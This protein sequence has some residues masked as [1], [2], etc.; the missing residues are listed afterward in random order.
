MAGWFDPFRKLWGW[1]YR[2]DAAPVATTTITWKGRSHHDYTWVPFGQD[3][4]YGRYAPHGRDTAYWKGR[5]VNLIEWHVRP[6]R[7]DYELPQRGPNDMIEETFPV[8]V[9]SGT[10]LRYIFRDRDGVIIPLTNYTL[11]KFVSK[12][13]GGTKA[14][15][16]AEFDDKAGGSVFVDDFSFDTTGIWNAQ[17]YCEDAEGV[18]L[19]GEPIQFRVVKNVEDLDAEELMIY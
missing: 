11:V 6:D 16:A 8:R 17:F 10:T 9:N 2:P 14:E 1:L 13:V 18:K 15:I 4:N 7:T 5:T 3:Y 19:Y 12:V